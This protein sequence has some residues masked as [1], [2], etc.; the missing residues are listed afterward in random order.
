MSVVFVDVVVLSVVS[1]LKVVSSVGEMVA[2]VVFFG[3][4]AQSK[5]IQSAVITKTTNSFLIFDNRPFPYFIKD[6][7]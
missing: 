3:V 2:S 7:Q 5:N 4:Q 1:L 6:L